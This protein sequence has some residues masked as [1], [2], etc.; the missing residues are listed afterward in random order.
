MKIGYH[1]IVRFIDGWWFI[2]GLSMVYSWL[3]D[4]L[5][6]V[7][8]GLVMVCDGLWSFG[9]YADIDVPPFSDTKDMGLPHLS[10]PW[11]MPEDTMRVYDLDNNQQS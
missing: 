1:K 7:Y 9:G 11:G 10:L 4:G 8:Y 6:T 2:D 5:L 3:I